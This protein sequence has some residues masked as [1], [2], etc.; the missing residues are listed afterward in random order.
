MV[1]SGIRADDSACR[2]NG[3]FQ[4]LSERIEQMAAKFSSD[5]EHF[6]EDFRSKSS[7]NNAFSS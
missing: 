6:K 3:E 4:K 7:R 1:R 5:L 2:Q